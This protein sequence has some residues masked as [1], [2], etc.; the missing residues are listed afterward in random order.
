MLRRRESPAAEIAESLRVRPT[1]LSF[2]LRVLSNSGLVEQHRAGRQRVYRVK[3]QLLNDV[4]RWLHQYDESNAA[5]MQ[6]RKK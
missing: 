6:H 5:T 3:A 1:T 2:H 4:F